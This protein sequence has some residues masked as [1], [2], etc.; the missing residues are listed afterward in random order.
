MGLLAYGTKTKQG[1]VL[2]KSSA[3]KSFFFFFFNSTEMTDY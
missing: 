2:V 1:L 3:Q